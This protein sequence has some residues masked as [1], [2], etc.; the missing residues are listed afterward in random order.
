MDYVTVHELRSESAK[1]WEKLEASEEIV[2]TRN[3]KPFAVL[4]HIEHQ[5]LVAILHA[6]R[7][8]RF[9]ANVRRMQRQAVE[10]GLDKLTMVEINVE[11]EAMRKERR[12]RDAGPR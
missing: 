7:G 1:V 8:E 5:D 10:Q 6:L 4:A 12:E 3:G 9:F 2:I 11:I